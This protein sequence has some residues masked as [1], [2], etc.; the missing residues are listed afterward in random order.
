MSV[1]LDGNR[2]KR[3][4][5]S[6][7]KLGAGL[8]ASCVSASLSQSNSQ[9]TE[10]GFTFQDSLDLDLFKSKLF[11]RGA[12]IQYDGWQMTAHGVN[13]KSGA[14]GPLLSVTA[15]SRFVVALKK[16]TGAKSWG[17]TSVSAWVQ[18]VAKSVGMKSIVQPGLGT[19]TIARKAPASGETPE[20]TWEVLAQQAKEVGVWLYEYGPT[21]VF[22]KPSWLVR[23]TSARRTWALRWDDWDTYSGGMTGMPEYSDDPGSEYPETLTVKLA[24][25]DADAAKVGDAVTLAG[26]NVGPMGGTWIVTSVDVPMKAATATVLTC[27][28]PIDPTPEPPQDNPKTSTTSAAGKTT[29]SGGG[30]SAPPV[31]SGSSGAVDVWVGNVNGRAI[32]MDGAFGAQCVDLANHYHMYAVGGSSMVYANGNGWFSAAPASL[33]SKYAVGG[34]NGETAGKGDI[35]CWGAF[36]GGGYGHVAIV[37][38]DLGNSLKVMTQ[39]PGGAHVDTLSKQGLQGYLRPKK[40]N[41]TSGNTSRGPV[42]VV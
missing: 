26:R 17:S 4:T 13:L 40:F 14:A 35:A 27:Q 33:Y 10:M 19:K 7:S 23:T 21:L 20:S 29:A 11:H 12:T 32:D 34:A 3:I 5:V 2:L 42:K 41:S 22:A 6:G 31:A 30:G 28:R 24:S 9:I 16:Q 15:P 38:Q 39:N 36:Y 25:P 1:F 18:G 37:L 8:E